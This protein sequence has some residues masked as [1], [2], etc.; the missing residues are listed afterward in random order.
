MKKIILAFFILFFTATIFA[1]ENNIEKIIVIRHGEKPFFEIGQLNC[2][3]LNRSLMLPGYFKNNFPKPGYIFAPNPSVEITRPLTHSQ[4]GYIRPLATIEPTAISLGLPVNVQV[5][6]NQPD[7]LMQILLEN[8]YHQSVIY[9]AWEHRNIVTLAHLMLTQ[10]NSSAI[11][12]S[13][14][15]FNYNMVFVFTIDWSKK[16][17]TVDFSVTSEGFKNIS[18]V[19]PN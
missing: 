7:K 10:F 14:S 3:G 8:K 11:V 12:P 5:G 18:K 16:P 19:C 1:S 15:V 4:F 2:Q 17:A 6:F 13:W 9:V